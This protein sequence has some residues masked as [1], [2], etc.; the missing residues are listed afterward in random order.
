MWHIAMPA[1]EPS[2]ASLA[3]IEWSHQECPLCARKRTCVP[4]YNPPGFQFS[5]KP[6]GAQ[7]P[8][9]TIRDCIVHHPRHK[10]RGKR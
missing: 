1:E 9:E 10:L 5:F 8:G 4:T 7:L 6:S 2:T 3:D